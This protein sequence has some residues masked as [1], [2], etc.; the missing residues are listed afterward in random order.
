MA[1][2]KTQIFLMRNILHDRC[3]LNGVAGSVYADI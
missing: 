3:K 2:S 1:M